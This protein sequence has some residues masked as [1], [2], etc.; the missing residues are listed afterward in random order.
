MQ[1]KIW[2]MPPAT[3]ATYKKKNCEK[4]GTKHYTSRRLVVKSNFSFKEFVTVYKDSDCSYKE[5]DLEYRGSWEETD[6]TRT[7][8]VRSC[9][10]LIDTEVM[11][12]AGM[13]PGQLLGGCDG[14]KQSYGVIYFEASGNWTSED[15]RS[16][17]FMSD[18]L[19]K[20]QEL[21]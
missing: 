20:T 18:H 17:R 15:G 13:M 9:H 12:T 4:E 2:S 3:S 8:F 21:N 1:S 16:F 10:K 11:T 14:F 19:K 5:F 7:T 6:A